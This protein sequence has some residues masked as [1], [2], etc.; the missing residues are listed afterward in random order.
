MNSISMAAVVP[1]RITTPFS[2]KRPCANVDSHTSR[3]TSSVRAR[4]YLESAVD[5]QHGILI[6][7]GVCAVSRHYMEDFVPHS[8]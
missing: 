3:P 2:K 4:T 8:P 5:G 7:E 6:R 1:G